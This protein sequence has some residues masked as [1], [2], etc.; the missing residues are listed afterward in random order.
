MTVPV[1]VLEALAEQRRAAGGGAH[2][3]APGAGVGGLP[4]EVADALETEHRIERVEGDH[5][6]AV[7]GVAR[8]GG[9]EAGHR[10]RF[11][12]ALLEDLTVGG[13]GVRQQHR[14]VD[15]LVL[16]PLRGVDLQLLEERV[17]AERAGLVGDDRHDAG[18]DRLVPAEVAEQ[19]GERLVVAWQP[20]CPTR[21]APRRRPRRTAAQAAA[22]RGRPAAAASRTAPD[23]ARPCTGT[24]PIDR[25]AVVRRVLGIEGG[26]RDLVLHVQP[27][28]QDDELI[29]GHLL[30]LV[31]RV[32]GFDVAAERPALDG[33]GEDHRRRPAPE[34]VDGGLVG[35]VEL[36]VVVAA[37][38]QVLRARRR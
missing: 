6:H 32:A 35:G 2:Q 18:T 20:A 26:V 17:H 25:R 22:A 14:C 29:L 8:A 7:G 34:V 37:A 38:R 30:D 10:A 16:L 13:L 24:R 27:V 4:D 19:A 15:R 12:D 33:L 9:D 28:A 1:L 21:A 23:G 31:R 5:R 3:E 36:P 11:G